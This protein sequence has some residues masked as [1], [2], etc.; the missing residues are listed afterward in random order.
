M[1]NAKRKRIDNVTESS[2]TNALEDGTVS[3]PVVAWALDPDTGFYRIGANNIGLALGGNKMIDFGTG[4]ISF[5]TDVAFD[6][7][8]TFTSNLDASSMSTS[9]LTTDYIHINTQAE[10]DQG[11]ETDPSLTFLNDNSTGIWSPGTGQ[12]AISTGA[13]K[14]LAIDSS[15]I[16]ATGYIM[17]QGATGLIIT[18][19]DGT[20]TYPSIK[21]ASDV[22]SGLRLVGSGELNFVIGS[23]DVHYITESDETSPLVQLGPS[24]TNSAPSY[25]FSTDPNSGIYNPSADQVGFTTG[26]T[27]SFNITTA[28]VTVPTLSIFTASARTFPEEVTQAG[29]TARNDAGTSFYELGGDVTP[30]FSYLLVGNLVTLYWNSEGARNV[31]LASAYLTFTSGLPSAIRPATDHEFKITINYDSVLEYDAILQILSTGTVKIYRT[32]KAGSYFGGVP[33]EILPG[34]CSWYK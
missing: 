21:F 31:R 30:D 13:T 3:G 12:V 19:A 17:Q 34:S 5:E 6:A 2:A 27:L 23:T 16:T 32:L 28:A 7:N 33:L 11:T 14:R 15:G 26:S 29:N 22:L 9:D 4:V 25:S 1:F 20:V 8:T 24:G 18:F 10:L